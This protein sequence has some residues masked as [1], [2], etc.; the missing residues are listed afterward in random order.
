MDPGPLPDVE[1]QTGADVRRDL[2]GLPGREI[3]ASG[4]PRHS[5]GGDPAL[6][7]LLSTT[8]LGLRLQRLLRA[9]YDRAC[10]LCGDT[11][12]VAELAARLELPVEDTRAIVGELVDGRLLVVYPPIGSYPPDAWREALDLMLSRLSEL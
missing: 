2:E 9:P 11:M 6:E 3:P 12:A 8:G 10:A 4:D 7:A 5:A 1:V